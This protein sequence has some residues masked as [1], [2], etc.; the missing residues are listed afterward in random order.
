MKETVWI[1]MLGSCLWFWG[2]VAIKVA[3]YVQGN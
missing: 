1:V 2:C 3:A